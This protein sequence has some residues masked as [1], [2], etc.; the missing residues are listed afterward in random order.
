MQDEKSAAEPPREAVENKQ[1]DC[2]IDHGN[3][4]NQFNPEIGT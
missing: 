3:C 2:S 1:L 4:G